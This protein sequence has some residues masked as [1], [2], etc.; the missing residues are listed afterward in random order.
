ME[1]G[2]KQLALLAKEKE[3]L[4][5]EQTVQVL[6]DEVSLDGRHVTCI[7]AKDHE[8]HPLTLKHEQGTADVFECMF[9]SVFTAGALRMSTVQH[10]CFNKE[11]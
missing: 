1:L 5:K 8:A 7:P 6:K 4:E 10:K 9:L 11:A 3:L 2:E